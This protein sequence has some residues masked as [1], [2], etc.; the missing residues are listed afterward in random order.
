MKAIDIEDKLHWSGKERWL[1]LLGGIALLAVGT[2]A[3]W[4]FDSIIPLRVLQFLWFIPNSIMGLVG[5]SC[6]VIAAIPRKTLW[7]MDI[8][9]AVFGD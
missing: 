5:I 8:L 2:W 7:L 1:V 9:S 3:I 4:W 6:I